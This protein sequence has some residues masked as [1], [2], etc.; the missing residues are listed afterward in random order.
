M[1][2]PIDLRQATER[3][4]AQFGSQ[5]AA[6]RSGGQRQLVATLQAQFGVTDADAQR[7]MSI[8]E[9]HGIICWINGHRVPCPGVL[10]LS[11]HWR[12][13]PSALQA[14]EAA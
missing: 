12:F 2:Y 3:L 11:G 13:H 9:R 1:N 5:F 8:L 10:E 6:S 4:V 7:V 14:L